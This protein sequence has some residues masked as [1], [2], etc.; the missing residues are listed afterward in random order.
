MN[1]RL[2]GYV[3][4]RDA[5][6]KSVTYGPNDDVPEWATHLITHTAAWAQDAPR[7]DSA[8]QEV[9]AHPEPATTDA[10]ERP[11]RGRPRKA[12]PDTEH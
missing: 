3:T 6:L 7:R 9:T 11:R 1:R 4:V 2:A 10:T 8:D 12:A 5:D